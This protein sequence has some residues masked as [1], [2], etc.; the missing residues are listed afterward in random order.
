M[1]TPPQLRLYASDAIGQSIYLD[2]STRHFTAT[3]PVCLRT[4]NQM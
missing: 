2:F 1:P 4:T 3:E